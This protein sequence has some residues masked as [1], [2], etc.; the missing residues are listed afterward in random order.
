MAPTVKLNKLPSFTRR[1]PKGVG[2]GAWF[3]SNTLSTTPLVTL[4]SPSLTAILNTTLDPP[5]VSSGVHANTP[6]V[7]TDPDGPSNKR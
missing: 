7:S 6:L 5:V 1:V 2:T 4:R 3:T